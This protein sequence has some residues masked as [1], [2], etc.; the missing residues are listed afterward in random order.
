MAMRSAFLLTIF[1]Y[2]V[3]LG[4]GLSNRTLAA[5]ASG[6]R[7]R[8][9]TQE[10]RDCEQC[11]AQDGMIH[12]LTAVGVQI[13]DSECSA[14]YGQIVNYLEKAKDL[15]GIAFVCEPDFKVSRN[16]VPRRVLPSKVLELNC[17]GGNSVLGTNDPKSSC[18]SNLE[19]IR[20]GAAWAVARAAKQKF[21][22]IVLAISDTGVDMTHPDLVNQFWKDPAD[23]SIG[24]NFITKTSDVTDDNGHGTHCAGNAAAQ[25]NNTLGIA[26]VANVNGPA[27]NVK[28]MILK[29]LNAEGS[30]YSS[31]AL[32]ALNYAVEHGAAISSHSYGAYYASQVFEDAFKNAAAANHVAVVAAGNDASTLDQ[33]PMYPCS[34]AEDIPSMLCVA[35]STSATK[36]IKLAYFSNAGTVTKIAAP[37]LDINSTYPGGYAS[38][39][40]TS[41]STPTVAGAAALVATLGPKGQ[42][43]TDAIIKSKTAGIPNDFNLANIGELDAL[44]AVHVALGQPTSP[45]RPSKHPGRVRGF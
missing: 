39:S 35:A 38:L 10:D 13:V 26:G 7:V 12:D 18:Q 32:S 29:F 45:P 11:F 15:T 8:S 41:M 9:L 4:E 16:P 44:N 25:T 2:V 22:D 19:V 27:P 43:I 3:A 6:G 42:E 1:L 31:D 5:A 20:I 36:D 30:G 28:L 34:F 21:K 14:S 23:G 17:T 37:G 40:G 33:V 24:H